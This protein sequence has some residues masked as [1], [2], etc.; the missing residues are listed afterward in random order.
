MSFELL[1][2]FGL[3]GFDILFSEELH[4]TRISASL[5]SP[6]SQEAGVVIAYIDASKYIV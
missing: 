2:L 1:S 3:V 6:P 4:P 5:L